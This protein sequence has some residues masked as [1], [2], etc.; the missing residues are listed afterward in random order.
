MVHFHLI[1][2][3]VSGDEDA[4]AGHTVTVKGNSLY[5]IQLYNIYDY[6]VEIDN[7]YGSLNCF[8]YTVSKVDQAYDGT[9]RRFRDMVMGS[10]TNRYHRTVC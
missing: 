3:H 2:A 5:W 10:V 1:D 6:T 4:A 7:E 8:W 9:W